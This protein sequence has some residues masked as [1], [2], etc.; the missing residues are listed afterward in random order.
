MPPL[1]ILQLRTADA[2]NLARLLT[3]QY[4]RRSFDER[5]DKPVSVSA[6]PQT[7]ALVVAAHPDMF[8]EIE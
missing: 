8:S 4:Q 2:G 3:E 6:D 1:R 7:N 5:R